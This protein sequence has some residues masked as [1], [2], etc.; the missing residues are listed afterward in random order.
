MGL[1]S[2]E[3]FDERRSKRGWLEKKNL[4]V[5]SVLGDGISRDGLM[6]S[7]RLIGFGDDSSKSEIGQLS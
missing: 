5:G 6:S 7:D 1:E 3:L 2:L 4:V